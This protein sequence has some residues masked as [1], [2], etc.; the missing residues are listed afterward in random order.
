MKKEHK[1]HIGD[2]RI[3]EYKVPGGCEEIDPE[4][5]AQARKILRRHC[6]QTVQTMLA[7]I[8]AGDFD[9]WTK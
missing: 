7:D 4:L 6:E 3:V 5:M 9:G 1:Y 2:I 8:Y